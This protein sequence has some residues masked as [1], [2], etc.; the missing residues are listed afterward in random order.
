MPGHRDVPLVAIA[1]VHP[2]QDGYELVTLDGEG[3]VGRGSR[4]AGVLERNPDDGAE[5]VPSRTQAIPRGTC[6]ASR[7]VEQVARGNRSLLRAI[8]ELDAR[9]VVRAWNPGRIS[10]REKDCRVPRPR[11]LDIGRYVR[12]RGHYTCAGWSGA[13]DGGKSCDTRRGNGQLHSEI[14]N[15]STHKRTAK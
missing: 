5:T 2:G 13:N 12:N 7:C 4:A 6:L 3:V 11:R 9:P 14:I 1:G 8:V 15:E 10:K